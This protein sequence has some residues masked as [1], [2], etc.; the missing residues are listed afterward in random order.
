M[1]LSSDA[2]SLVSKAIYEDVGGGDITSKY[3]VSSEVKI[4]AEVIV[5][6]TLV[7]CG[8]FLAKEVFK[9]VDKS[10]KVSLLKKEGSFLRKG[11]TILKLEGKAVS[12]LT[13]E[14]VALNFLMHLSGIASRAR[15]FANIAKNRKV[16][17]LDT[18]KTIPGLRDLHKYAVRTGGLTNH[19]KGLWDDIIIKENHLLSVGVK[20]KT[21]FD[22]QYVITLVSNIKKAKKRKVEIEVE[23][24]KEFKSVCNCGPDVILLDNFGPSRVKKAIK[25]RNKYYSHIKLEAS[26][27]INRTN[28][29]KFIQTKVDYIS[30]GSLTHSPQAKDISLEIKKHSAKC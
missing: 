13:A 11:E 10:I 12:I 22:E 16:T 23:T 27:R 5:K 9:Q 4:K 28:I 8:L 14:R 6:E 19:R 17:I 1:G 21:K 15:E 2:R 7:V 25:Y 18:R 20:Q 3:T 30:I 24:L 26:G 29:K